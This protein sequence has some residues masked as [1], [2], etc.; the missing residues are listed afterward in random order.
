VVLTLTLTAIILVAGFMPLLL[1]T[2]GTVSRS[3]VCSKGL[4]PCR[5]QAPEH[6]V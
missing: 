4:R 5:H 1:K 2:R 3:V 6:L